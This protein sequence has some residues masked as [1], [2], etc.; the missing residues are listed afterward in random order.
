[1]TTPDPLA[2]VTA[3]RLPAAALAALAPV[4]DRAD[5]R[6]LPDGA[7]AWVTW[8]AGASAVARCLHPV[9]G[10]TFYVRRDGHWFRLG[11]RLPAADGP[12]PGDGRPLAGM[13]TPARCDPVP[14]R[15]RLA[16]VSARGPFHQFHVR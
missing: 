13:L 8:P 2:A 15:L 11:S 14:P 12:P 5:V 1:M 7:A 3:A 9:A 4:R 16:S 10:V 6:V